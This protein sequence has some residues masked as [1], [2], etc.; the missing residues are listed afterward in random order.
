MKIEIDNQLHAAEAF[1]YIRSMNRVFLKPNGLLHFYEE[2]ECDN[3]GRKA[4]CC[5]SIDIGA[6]TMEAS[7]A[8]LKLVKANIPS[9]KKAK[10][11]PVELWHN[12]ESGLSVCEDCDNKI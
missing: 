9:L 8:I 2:T 4:E 5:N 1:N 12:E 6:T 10:N 11:E 3:C 7:T